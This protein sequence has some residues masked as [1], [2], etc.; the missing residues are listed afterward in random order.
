MSVKNKNLLKYSEIVIIRRSST[1]EIISAVPCEMCK[2]LL[3]KYKIIN[4]KTIINNKVV[5]YDKCI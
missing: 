5:K 3:N 4:I 2:K 1:N